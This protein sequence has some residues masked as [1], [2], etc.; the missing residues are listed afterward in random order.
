M[1]ND[2]HWDGSTI[3]IQGTH[4][5][6]YNYPSKLNH[7]QY[8]TYPADIHLQQHNSGQQQ[9]SQNDMYY[10][11]PSNRS[12]GRGRIGQD[13]NSHIHTPA[14]DNKMYPS[15]THGNKTFNNETLHKHANPLVMPV[16][17]KNDDY[18][19]FDEVKI[20]LQE[21]V[22]LQTPKNECKVARL[23]GGKVEVAE[24]PNLDVKIDEL[25][26]PDSETKTAQ[27]KTP[28]KVFS[29]SF[30]A[31]LSPVSPPTPEQEVKHLP[32][33]DKSTLVSCL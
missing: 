8:S 9:V 5:N 28:M 22:D 13:F 33:T 14:F 31:Q 10:T 2:G 16:T 17:N 29:D 32:P 26:P 23:Q 15:Q 12:R 27:F 25:P 19:V 4:P 21:D 7:Q 24:A 30:E 6:H 11:L 20:G 3:T 1:R 18:K